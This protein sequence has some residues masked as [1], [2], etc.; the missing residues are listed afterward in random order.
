VL[1]ILAS[2]TINTLFGDNGILTQAQDS[3]TQSKIAEVEEAANLIYNAKLIENEGGNEISLEYV[4]SQLQEEGYS[5]NSVVNDGSAITG[6]T[7]SASNV[8]ISKDGGTAEITVS[9]SGNSDAMQ[10]YAVVEGKNY[11]ITKEDGKISIAKTAT[12]IGSSS[13][14]A[15]LTATSDNTSSVA[16][17]TISGNTITLNSGGTVGSST[18]TV[19]YGT[20][21]ATCVASVVTKPTTDSVASNSTP[22]FSTDYGTIDIIWLSGTS[23]T[24]VSSTPNNPTSSLSGM[25]P[26]KW[27]ETKDDN[28]NVTGWTEKETTSSDTDWYIYNEGTGT[29]DN[30]TS[31][32]ANAKNTTSGGTS[33][34]VWIPRYAYRITY[35]ESQEA[36]QNG[37]EPT[38]YYDGYGLWN[39]SDGSVNY[40]LEDGI[41]TVSYNGNEYIIHPAFMGIGSEDVGGGF[42]TDSNGIEGFWVAKYE[43]SRT[44]ATSSSSG[45]GYDTTFLSVPNV[46]SARSINIGNMYTV[47]L[48]YDKNKYSHMMKNSEWGAVAFL[49]QSKYGRNGYE[50][51]INNSS[52]YITGIGGGSTSATDSDTTYK[53]NTVTG[54][55]ASTT[56]NIYG[57]YDMSGGAWEYV[58]GYDKKG[59]STYLAGSSY[60]VNMTKNAKDSSNNYI[61]TKYITAYNNGT[62][63]Y[64]AASTLYKVSI[65][66]DA[67]KEVRK[68]SSTYGWFSDYSYFVASGDPFFKR[69]G[70]CGNGSSAG[71]FYSSRYGGNYD[72][73]GSFRVVLCP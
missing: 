73:Y 1:L 7:L 30:L 20:Y 11:L 27:T 39:A 41:K 62:S 65:T 44:G 12:E 14:P 4:T 17:R 64:S 70:G 8:S 5:V 33:Y 3:K 50:I 37:D 2:V 28:G 69:G 49:T 60:G 67:T 34:V 46:Q 56:G 31:K 42:G 72:G 57:I 38:G 58:A 29:A 45:S 22:S 55:K 35:Y 53:Y 25:T 43:M 47:S 18:I 32:W 16:V 54:A 66:G 68:K 63:E 19:S 36:W 61:S 40:K 10:Y 52:S 59:S 71:V 21:T 9:Y 13:N 15:T 26:V 6:I 48:S 51:D 23:T 24:E